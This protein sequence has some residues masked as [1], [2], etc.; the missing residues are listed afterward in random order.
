MTK[1]Y[2][3]CKASIYRWRLQNGEEYNA[4]QREYFSTVYRDKHRESRKRKYAWEKAAKEFR[5]ILI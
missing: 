2:D 5:A 1:L 3:N 4:Y